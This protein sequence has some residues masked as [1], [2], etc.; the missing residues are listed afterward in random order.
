MQIIELFPIPVG[1]VN[2]KRKL[3]DQEINYIDELKRDAQVNVSK[4]KTSVDRHVLNNELFIDLKKTI[5]EHLNDYIK[6]IFEPDTNV[7]LYI[8]NSW[9]NWTDND[10]AHHLHCHINSLISC[11]LYINTDIESDCITFNRPESSYLFGNIGEF[12]D[13]PTTKWSVNDCSVTAVENQLLIF[14]SRLYHQ[15]LPRLNRSKGTRISL[16]LNTWFTGTVGSSQSA[17]ELNL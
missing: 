10:T 16:S 4:N 2:L 15:V 9:V 6:T 1:V 14:P 3:N 12:S 7:Q 11:V 5:T 17:S 8:T 13:N